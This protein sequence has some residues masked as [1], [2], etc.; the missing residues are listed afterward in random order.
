[1][2]W[3]Q[4]QHLLRGLQLCIVFF[5]R[6]ASLGLLTLSAAS[7]GQ[8]TA[9]NVYLSAQQSTQQSLAV[10]SQSDSHYPQYTEGACILISAQIKRFEQ[11]RHLPAYQDALKN[12]QRHCVSPVVQ[13]GN[14]TTLT[15]P[16]A[17]QSHFDAQHPSGKF[18]TYLADMPRTTAEQT[19]QTDKYKAPTADF[20]HAQPAKHPQTVPLAAGWPPNH[21][22]PTTGN[23]MSLLNWLGWGLLAIFVLRF[24]GRYSRGYPAQS[25]SE[26]LGKIAE[27]ELADILTTRFQA[28]YSHYH[29][30][31]L[32]ST[33]GDLTE[34]D[35]LL[36]S[37][38]GMFVFEV[39]NIQGWIF[40]AAQQERWVVKH[41]RRQHSF[42]NPTHQNYKHTEALAQLLELDGNANAGN[43]YSVV[44]FTRRAEFK[45]PMPDNVLYIDD[46]AYYVDH[47]CAQGRR[48]SD[49]ALLRY[50]SRLNLF[51]AE[52]EQ[53]RKQHKLQQQGQQLLR[54]LN[55]RDGLNE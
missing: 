10:H 42:Q 43:I 44:V 22:T 40:G 50:T 5:T 26:W 37:P 51:A 33:Q 12:Q 17:D 48:F 2:V 13:A 46:V 4:G 7:A 25:K 39:K 9:P 18:G 3:L 31:V 54:D 49:E 34:I 41:F 27:R 28:G 32:P 11:Q 8:S 53:L 21:Q 24:L 47:I 23:P 15:N 20:S 45:T 55:Q 36:V 14:N 52:A 1:M 35:Y 6:V 30:L 19:I 29:N 16:A 38:F